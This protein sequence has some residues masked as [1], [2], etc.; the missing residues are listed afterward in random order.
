MCINGSLAINSTGNTTGNDSI[1]ED[2]NEKM[3][4]YAFYYL[5][6]AGAVLVSGYLQ[7]SYNKSKHCNQDRQ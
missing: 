2:F 3:S 5:Y 1:A 4:T 6:I 7:V